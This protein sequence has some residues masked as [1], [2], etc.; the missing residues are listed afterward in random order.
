MKWRTSDRPRR[1]LPWPVSGG[2]LL[3][4]TA[5]Y[6][7]RPY[8]ATAFTVWPAWVG[9]TIGASARVPEPISVHRPHRSDLVGTQGCVR[10]LKGGADRA[11]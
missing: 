3:G 7:F 2:W 11:F 4:L 9:L 10:A 6:L 1:Q 5:I 8:F